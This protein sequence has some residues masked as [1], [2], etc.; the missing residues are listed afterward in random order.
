[1][2]HAVNQQVSQR[3][4]V[5]V[6][7]RTASSVLAVQCQQTVADEHEGQH[8]AVQLVFDVWHQPAQIFKD[9]VH[10]RR[11][12]ICAALR[13]ERLL[14]FVCLAQLVS[15]NGLHQVVRN[16]ICTSVF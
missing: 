3:G 14:A 8:N 16:A 15:W 1:M 6:S 2:A 11:P 9:Q 10:R 12:H 7:S 13:H 5:Q 4:P